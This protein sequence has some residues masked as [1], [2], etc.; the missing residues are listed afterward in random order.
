MHSFVTPNIHNFNHTHQ[1]YLN[2]LTS[3]PHHNHHSD[4]HHAHNLSDSH[5]NLS[6]SNQNINRRQSLSHDKASNILVSNKP[7]EE[8]NES[9]LKY[10]SSSNSFDINTRNENTKIPKS[11]ELKE[12]GLDDTKKL[13]NQQNNDEELKSEHLNYT[14]PF[15]NY[16]LI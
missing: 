11:I 12:K 4:H 1:N 2:H 9:K 6:S 3:V 8:F 10:N 13:K 5:Q 16:S 7:E 15:G 14:R